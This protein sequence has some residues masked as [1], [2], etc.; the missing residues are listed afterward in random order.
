MEKL[1][2]CCNTLVD[3]ESA[4]I[5]ALGG[6]GNVKY[7]CEECDGYLNTVTRGRDAFEIDD[8]REK[9]CA[10]IREARIDDNFTLKVVNGILSEAEARRDAIEKGEYDFSKEEEDDA[11]TEE[12]PEELRETEEDKLADE[13]EREAAKK[14]DKVITIVS[15]VVFAAVIGYLAYRF[16]AGYFF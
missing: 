1:C 11:A 13:K 8:A 3:S 14:W 10:R 4:A 2:S 9:L 15:A 12:V 5:L 6:Y 16:I 7:L